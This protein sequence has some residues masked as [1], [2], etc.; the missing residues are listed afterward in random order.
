VNTKSVV[1]LRAVLPIFTLIFAVAA[2]AQPYITPF[3]PP[4]WSDKIVVT[5]NPNSTTDTPAIY[6]TNEVYVDW[7]VLN[8][9]NANA[10][11]TFDVDLYTNS[12]YV[13]TWTVGS[14]RA[15]S[16]EYVATPGFDAGTFPAG[17]NT[18]EIVADSTDEYEYPPST[19]TKTFVVYA[20][21]L[22]SLSAPVLIS[23]AN[24]SLNQITSPVFTWSS[25][26]NAASYEIIVATNAADLPASSNTNATSGGPSVIVDANV[27]GTTYT[28][29][30][31]LDPGT[32]YY[33]QVNARV[34]SV[35]G[36]W[37]SVWNFT[38]ANPPAGLTILPVFDSTI[39]SDP[40]AATIESTIRAACAVYQRDFSDPITVSITFK[41]MNS[42]LGESSWSYYTF[43]YTAYR[44]ALAASA[45]TADDSTSL[46]HLPVQ[47][48]NPVN[49]NTVINVKTASA[50]DLGLNSGTSGENVG[51]IFLYTGIMNLSDAQTDPGKYSLFSTCCH[52]MDEVLATGSALDQVFNGGDTPTGS[53]FPE[54]LFRYDSSGNRSYTTSGSA[55]S[56]F[57]IDGTT[58]L[59]Q[60]NQVSSGDYGDWYSY[61]GG[62]IPEVQDAFATAG[63][64]PN[65][66]VEL[67]VLD[68]LG[69]HRVIQEPVPNFT[70]V[71]RSGNN[72]N[73][74]W[75]AIS[76]G[77]YQVLDSTNLTSSVWSNLGGSITASNSTASY[78]DTIGP[79]QR[80]FYRV[81]ILSGASPSFQ[82]N[83]VG[84]VTPPTGWGTSVFNPSRP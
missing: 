81:E 82:P 67:R 15:N 37:S 34:A 69:Y 42:G 45:T 7:A 30:N 4:G 71:K 8:S 12:V 6:T 47:T 18:V 53:I 41:E 55:T 31:P 77:S 66:G 43:S 46:A 73:L 79:S 20:P 74:V 28:P 78:T 33:W 49:G 84:P 80:R 83:H 25:V 75:T 17:V 62:Q 63:A 56:W 61:N 5:T 72:I 38:T 51:T 13:T 19:Y 22:P 1:W 68:V 24:G 21:I 35:G 60:F 32:K 54:D 3:Q 16:Y 52:E 59:A 58:D 23:P 27:T 65:L 48:G 2:H 29:V 9:G 44:T 64:S 10:N 11:T 76:G 40:E 39:T 36:P 57:S 14:L 70:S 50:W 26:S